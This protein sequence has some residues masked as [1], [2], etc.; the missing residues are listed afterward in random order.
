MRLVHEKNGGRIFFDKV[1]KTPHT[2]KMEKMTGK[3]I[4]VLKLLSWSLKMH[5]FS[6]N[7]SQSWAN[8]SYFEAS[9]VCLEVIL[10]RLCD[11]YETVILTKSTLKY[12]KIARILLNFQNN[13]NNSLRKAS[14]WPYRNIILTLYLTFLKGYSILCQTL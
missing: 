7:N 6:M 3:Q 5:A 11:S 4:W 10:I 1:L 9:A 14:V 8:S 12:L 13:H 2:P